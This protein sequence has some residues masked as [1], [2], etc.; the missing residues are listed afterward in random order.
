[1]VL[2]PPLR[3]GHDTTMEDHADFFISRTGADAP[4]AD[5]IGRILED[6]GYRVV[7]QQWERPAPLQRAVALICELPSG[8]ARTAWFERN[9]H[10]HRPHRIIERRCNARG[11]RLQSF[12]ADFRSKRATIQAMACVKKYRLIQLVSSHQVRQN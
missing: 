11:H 8:V 5:R 1:M 10:A 6:A 2:A 4:F 12:G 9:D 3:Q 7:L